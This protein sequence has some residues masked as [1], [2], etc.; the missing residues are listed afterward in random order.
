MYNVHIF[1]IICDKNPRIANIL[2]NIKKSYGLRTYICR[3][4]MLYMK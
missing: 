3:V 1:L 2:T 4:P